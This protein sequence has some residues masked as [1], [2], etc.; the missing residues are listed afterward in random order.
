MKETI[1]QIFHEDNC[2]NNDALTLRLIKGIIFMLIF[3]IYIGESSVLETLSLKAW[4]Y[5][6]V[7]AFLI[8]M[9]KYFN[10][11]LFSFKKLTVRDISI[12]IIVT[13][14]VKL[15]D[16]LFFFLYSGTTLNQE[17][18]QNSI[19]DISILNYAIFFALL[20]AILEEIVFRGI[21]L[22]VLFKDH[23]FIGLIVSS[24]LFGLV[25]E[26][27]NFIEFL[28]YFYAGLFFGLAYLMTRRIEVVILIHFLGN[29]SAF[30]I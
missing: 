27:S 10:I 9:L 28:P 1:R 24:V 13:V 17:N 12:I 3:V 2:V 15:L 29:F 4:I 5:F 23:L 30:W 8:Y 16:Q 14:G 20:P 26:F 18:I 22:R 11:N 6:I 7:L 25:H 19:Q 21:I